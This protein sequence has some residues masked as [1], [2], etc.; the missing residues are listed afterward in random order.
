MEYPIVVSF[1]C[2]IDLEHD[3]RVEAAKKD[4][5]RSEFIIEAI[6]EKLERIRVASTQRS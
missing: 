6:R 2:P 3:T 1:R 4:M 5:N